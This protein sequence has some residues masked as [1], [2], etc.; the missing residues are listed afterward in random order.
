MIRLADISEWQDS[1]DAQ[2]YINAGHTCLIVRAHSGYRPDHKWPA[3]RDYLR[4]FAFDALGF[5]HY[6]VGD[7]PAVDQAHDYINTVG[8]LRPNEFTV[9][10]SEEGS[11]DQTGR[12]AAWCSVV[13][14]HYGR[15]S[16]IYASES[17]YREKLG[18]AARWNR[19]RW[20][21]AYRSTE[22]TD[23]HELWQNSDHSNLPGISGDGGDGNI[24]HGNGQEFAAVF[25][26]LT[27]PKAEDLVALTSFV[28]DGTAHVVYE[29]KDGSLW[30]TW[31]KPQETGWHGGEPGKQIAGLAPFAPNPKP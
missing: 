13:D 4:R 28:H 30:Y 29:H 25:C 18:G 21:A 1:I 14:A 3:R 10:D 26:H 22:P 24:F 12:V 6:L 11:G 19:P 17:W 27:T 7:R 2:T 8:D 9:V 16:T 31:Q 5:Y 20:M 23:P 15:T